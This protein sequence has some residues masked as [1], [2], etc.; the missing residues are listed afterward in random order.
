MAMVFAV[1][2]PAGK[3]LAAVW[4]MAEPASEAITINWAMKVLITVLD[5][6]SRAML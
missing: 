4:P 2:T 6:S 1:K 3:E 5:F